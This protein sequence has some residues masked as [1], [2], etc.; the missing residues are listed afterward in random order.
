M[1]D[2][3]AGSH[4]DVVVTKFRLNG[5]S[6]A[7]TC[8][9]VLGVEPHVARALVK[10]F[11]AVV[12]SGRPWLEADAIMRAFQAAGAKAQLKRHAP[13]ERVQ[14]AP[15][16]EFDVIQHG[17]TYEI[18]VGNRP[19]HTSAT[20]HQSAAPRPMAPPPVQDAELQQ[21]V[22]VAKALPFAT[23]MVV[24]SVAVTDDSPVREDAAPTAPRDAAMQEAL[25]AAREAVRAAQEAATAASEA[26]ASARLAATARQPLPHRAV[27]APVRKAGADPISADVLATLD[28]KLRLM[29]DAPELPCQAPIQVTRSPFQPTFDLSKR[30]SDQRPTKWRPPAPPR[31][32]AQARIYP[33]LLA[34]ALWTAAPHPVAFVGIASVSAAVVLSRGEPPR[35]VHIVTRKRVRLP[36]SLTKFAEIAPGNEAYAFLANDELL[37]LRLR[38]DPQH[39]LL[40]PKASVTGEKV[41]RARLLARAADGNVAIGQV[42]AEKSEDRDLVPPP[43]ATSNPNGLLTDTG[44]TREWD[45]TSQTEEEVVQPGASEREPIFNI[46]PRSVHGAVGAILRRSIAG[47]HN[48]TVEWPDHAEPEA[49][50]RGV[51]CML[52]EA[53]EGMGEQRISR[54][55]RTGREVPMTVALQQQMDEHAEALRAAAGGDTVNFIPVC[56]E[57]D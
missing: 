21:H 13:P 32:W 52:V 2:P 45:V 50:A 5:P 35:R 16:R 46:T 4:W 19:S 54:V 36:M 47:I 30:R 49:Q 44:S 29:D 12:L 56:L 57:N 34:Q 15:T 43:E 33:L 55:L 53:R 41:S 14:A 28:L 27:A 9:D 6:P 20:R 40:A 3:R 37:A 23:T 22:A 8:R 11:P 31:T 48:V 24:R 26:A 38:D 7:V 18:P 39:Q 1:Q 51:R 42:P 10:T 25:N 17:A